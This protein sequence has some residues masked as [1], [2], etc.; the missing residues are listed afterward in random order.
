[1]KTHL[2]KIRGEQQKPLYVGITGDLNRRLRDH[3]EKA[4]WSEVR[5]IESEEFD[6]RKA[7][8]K[9]EEIAIRKLQPKFNRTHSDK[10]PTGRYVPP[11]NVEAGTRKLLSIQAA[12]EYLGVST[13][14]IRRMISRGD[15]PAH[16]VSKRLLRVDLA[17]VESIL[18]PVPSASWK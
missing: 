9:A 16:R 17:D 5:S 15:I 8:A 12:A 18:A 14:T 11:V 13:R 4:W 2:Y 7:A 6:D 1:M 3:S 10:R